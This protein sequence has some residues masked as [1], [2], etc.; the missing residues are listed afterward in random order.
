MWGNVQRFQISVVNVENWSLSHFK[1]NTFGIQ[2]HYSSAQHDTADTHTTGPK[3]ATKHPPRTLTTDEPL[4]IIS[5]K[6]RIIL[7]GDGF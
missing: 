4:G 3:Y 1:G 2:Q 5:I 6:Y 7:T